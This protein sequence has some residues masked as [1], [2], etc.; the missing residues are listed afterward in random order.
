ME[1]MQ[2]K[3]ERE[4]RMLS[5]RI[6]EVCVCVCVWCMRVNISANPTT[7]ERATSK[8]V[9]DIQKRA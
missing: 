2:Q 9:G 5:H 7:G 8:T 3:V 4:Q 1:E 6:R